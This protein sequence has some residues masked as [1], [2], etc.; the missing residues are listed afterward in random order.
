MA[1][2]YTTKAGDMLDLI[3][4][5]KYAGRQSGAV[6]AV[7]DANAPLALADRGPVLPPG[8]TII[9]PDIAEPDASKSQ[10]LWD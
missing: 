7:L 4:Y 6:E 1:Q 10:K 5:R 8:I 3:C 9:L 2:I